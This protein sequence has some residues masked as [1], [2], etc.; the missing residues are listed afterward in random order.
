MQGSSYLHELWNEPFVIP[1]KPQKMSDLSDIS[2]GRLFLDGFYFTL[3]SGY[4]F[5]YSFEGLSFSPACSSFWNMAS[6]LSRWLA[7][8]FEKNDCII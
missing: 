7:R 6:S 4:S 1:C 8:S 3:I 2:R 5:G